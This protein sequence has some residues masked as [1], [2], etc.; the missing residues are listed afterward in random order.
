GSKSGTAGKYGVDAVAVLARFDDRVLPQ[1]LRASRRAS[2]TMGKIV[3]RD[4]EV[5]G[6][7][8]RLD[9]ET[10]DAPA[11]PVDE[12]PIGGAGRECA[13]LFVATHRTQ[14]G[15]GVA[16]H[17]DRGAAGPNGG[18]TLHDGHLPAG[19]DQPVRN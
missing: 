19:S 12:L 16:S 15:D 11:R 10:A 9:G 6:A 8:G 1:D 14:R 4:L 18:G 13:E 3:P 5:S 17:V 2:E 7:A